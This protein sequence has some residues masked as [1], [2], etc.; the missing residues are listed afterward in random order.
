MRALLEVIERRRSSL[1]FSKQIHSQTKEEILTSLFWDGLKQSSLYQH[2]HQLRSLKKPNELVC[3]RLKHDLRAD[4]SSTIDPR[5]GEGLSQVGPILPKNLR[6]DGY[7][8]QSARTLG[9][10]V[11]VGC[12]TGQSYLCPGLLLPIRLRSDVS[13]FDS[14]L[15]S[16]GKHSQSECLPVGE[17]TVHLLT[18]G[19][20]LHWFDIPAFF[21]EAKRVLAPGGVLAI[22]SS[23]AVY[24]VMEDEE[25]DYQLRMI[26]NKLLYDD[27]KA[28]RSPK[29]QQ[30]FEQYSS[31]EFPFEDVVR[32]R[33]IGH[34]YVGSAADAVGYIKSM[35]SFQN[36]RAINH[37]RADQ[38]LQD[39]QKSIMNILKVS[40][41]PG[42]TPLVYRRDYFLILCRMDKMQTKEKKT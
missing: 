37:F 19:T 1:H 34:T 22:Y 9:L 5:S 2:L 41:E 24:P 8:E 38:L 42:S 20:C 10:A 35:S 21:R 39:Y 27:L 11:D 4:A 7:L 23:W 14:E 13:K 12:G 31:V 18:A 28:Y 40:T 36:F 25:K 29:V 33:N 16:V 32:S 15:P 17:E 30:M 6:G 3:G 26:T